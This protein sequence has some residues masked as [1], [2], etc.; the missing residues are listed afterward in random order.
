MK[1]KAFLT[2]L[3]LYA[4]FVQLAAQAKPNIAEQ[5]KTILNERANNGW[6]GS[7]YVYKQGSVLVN[8]GFGLADRE[9]KKSQTAQTVFSIGSVTK[10]FT[11]AAILKLES[12]GKLSVNDKLSQYFV[13]APKDKAE[14]TLHQLLTHTAGL[15]P[16][17]G[18]DYDNV[19]AVA[20]AKLAFETPLNNAPGAMYDYSN[21]GFSLLG[22]IVE[23]VSGIGYEQYL[24][25]KLWLPAGM[26]RTGYLL[27]KFD[28]EG[29]AVGY[30]NGKRWGTA[31]DRPWGNDGPS[32]HLRAN[33][34]VL[35]TAGDMGKWYTALKNNTVLHKVA[36]D[37]LFTP[38][39]AE[40]AEGTSHYGYG[41]VVQLLDGDKLIWHNGGNGVYNANM[42]F[43]PEKDVCIV[44]SSNSNNKIS[45]DVAMHL[46]A[47]VLDKPGLA[48][49]SEPVDFM[50]N[51][52]SN[53]IFD[54]LAQKGAAYFLAN[55]QAILKAAGFDFKDDMLLLGVGERLLDAEEWQLGVA[56]YE[57]YTE[58]FPNI[59][60]AWNH[61]GRCK[62]GLGDKVGAKAAW[63]QSVKLRPKNNPAV[64]W[65]KQ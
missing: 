21:V 47:I 34:G 65:L 43:L 45:D 46:L 36:V 59:V 55:S 28:K 49:T 20:F 57:V 42:T 8:D 25:E 44:V 56:L 39:V 38:H 12:E 7:V 19:D 58:L 30:R 2:C 61:L 16:A 15:P 1:I 50:N 41:W 40:N 9:A 53:A 54:E 60:V 27:P 13:D 29:L 22:I 51:P 3:F 6:S 18:D 14:I 11:A 4:A 32:W 63:E 48:P 23:K 31:M 17:L 52:V 24:R 35:S 33:G 26:E 10:Q 62:N 64:E 5:L 37:K